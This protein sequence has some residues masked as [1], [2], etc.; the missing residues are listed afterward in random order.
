MGTRRMFS[1]R[2]I[3]SAKFL[4]MGAGAQ[5]LYFHLCLAADD[6]GVVEAYPV[7]RG[8]G[9][10]DDDLQNLIGRGF[11][12]VLDADNEVVLIADW[13]EHNK[14]R[15]DR[16]TPSI[17]RHLIA[18]KYPETPLIEQKA[19][20]DTKAGKPADGPRTD[21]GR[22]TDGQWTDNGRSMDGPR[23]GH[24]RAMDRL[25]KDKLSK[26][27]I[28]KD[29]IGEDRKDTRAREDKHRYGEYNHVLLTDRDYIR[30]QNDFPNDWQSMIKTLDEYLENNPSKHYANH[31]MTMRNWKRRDDEKKRAE[32]KS[33]PMMEHEGPRPV[34][35]GDLDL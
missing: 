4:K 27:K 10:N 12:L 1:R 21:S 32:Q 19:R 26:D 5:N 29:K 28:G 17:Y 18:E 34:F 30:L 9:A 35:A 15:A 31:S 2:I 16:I 20:S 7:R 11:V 33:L 3:N 6:D 25:S 23:T 22:S 24:G 13:S 14:I 8:T